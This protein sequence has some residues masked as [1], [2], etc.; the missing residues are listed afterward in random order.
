M[1]LGA[2]MTSF[3]IFSFYKKIRTF[4]KKIID[5]FCQNITCHEVQVNYGNKNSMG[6]LYNKHIKS[7]QDDGSL[8]DLLPCW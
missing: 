3:P 1:I 5:I 4:Y 7:A 2:A 8:K 6:I